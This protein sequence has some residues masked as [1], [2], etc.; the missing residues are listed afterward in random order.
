MKNK[1]EIIVALVGEKNSF[2]TRRFKRGI[3]SAIKLKL[4]FGKSI[5]F[6]YKYIENT[7]NHKFNVPTFLISY[8]GK[9]LRVTYNKV[10][11]FFEHIE[12]IKQAIKNEELN[13][14][15]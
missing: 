10:E 8:R 3:E 4:K 13:K 2:K 12:N 14:V 11:E 6:D 1:S 5:G 7:S 9:D 15:S